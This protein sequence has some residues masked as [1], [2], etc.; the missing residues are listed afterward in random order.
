MTI[1]QIQYQSEIALKSIS[2]TANL[3]VEL[4]IMHVLKKPREFLYTHPDYCLTKLQIKKINHSLKLRT[5]GMPIALITGHKEFYGLDL[6][7]SRKT[8]IPRPETELLVESILNNKKVKTIAD[9]GTGSGC[10][11][12]ALAKNNKKLK[13]YASDISAGAL[14]IAK[15]NTQNHKI[16][17]ITFLK[18]DLLI[19]YK[20]IALDAIVAN[21]PYLSNDIYEQNIFNLA[22]EPKNALVAGSTGL[23]YYKKLLIQ[24]NNLESKP[25]FIYLE[26]LDQQT[27]P[28]KELIKKYLPHLHVKFKKDL[29]GK[30]RVAIIT[31]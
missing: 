3:D 1:A 19:P 22:H 18:G 6:I 8:L 12:L 27:I 17:R 4:L 16:K 31:K 15:I 2:S 11:S 26:I 23:D 13:I 5:K 29:S 21:L 9:I 7:V 24:L 14:K 30:N 28:L 25:N 10:I 20:K